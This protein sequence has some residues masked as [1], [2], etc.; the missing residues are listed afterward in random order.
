[1]R[2]NPFTDYDK[3]GCLKLPLVLYASLAYL[4]KGYVIWI[5]S[6]SYRQEPAALLN[7][8]YPSRQDFYGALILGIPAL[9]CAVVFS[10]RRVDMPKLIQWM[11][12]KIRWMLIVSGIIQLCFSLWQGN[13]S[14]HNLVHITSNYGVII[15][16]VIISLILLYYSFNQR[17]IDVSKQ[18][19]LSAGLCDSNVE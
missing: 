13:V 7:I 10:L 3:H 6:L 17:V 14:S 9:I 18:Y 2:Y 4:L 5:V 11:W 8:F 12:H 15:D 1:M 19:P 16:F